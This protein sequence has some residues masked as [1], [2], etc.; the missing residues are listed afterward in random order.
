MLP[1]PTRPPLPAALRR[2][3][4]LSSVA[5]VVLLAL[6]VAGLLAQSRFG[7]APASSSMPSLTTPGF[8]RL[9]A[10]SAPAFSLPEL[11]D[12]SVKVS[13]ASLAGRPLLLNFWST[14]C[15]VCVTEAPALAR[16]QRLLAGRVRLVGID[17][18]ES[19]PAAGLAFA[20]RHHLDFEM[21]YDGSTTVAGRYTDGL[22]VTFFVSPAG[23]L[24]AENL[25]AVTAASLQHEVREV[26]GA[27]A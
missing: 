12:P 27:G 2:R 10:R 23:K 15:T 20:A 6:V 5:V 21:L 16:A 24:V 3:L 7:S 22:P 4:L 26:F 17:T 9:T 25:G 13:L 11:A 8:V 19:S 18:A 1:T 14:T